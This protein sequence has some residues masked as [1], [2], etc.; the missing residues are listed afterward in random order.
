MKHKPESR[1]GLLILT[2]A[3]ALAG[4]F[5]PWVPH[6]AAGLTVLGLDLAEYVKF[7]SPVASGQIALQRELFYLPLVTGSIAASLLASRRSLPA[8]GRIALWLIAIPLALA[9]LPPAWNLET[10]RSAEFRL[11]IIAIA[12]CLIP[13]LG[14]PL[15]RYL[16]GRLVLAFIALL[17]IAAALLPAWG[18]LRVQ[19][20]IAELYRYPLLPGWGFW[21]C[22]AGNFLLALCAVA[23]MLPRPRSSRV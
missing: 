20:V 21:T 6:R 19:P 11:Q 15:T 13:V 9:M 14:V 3:I 8:L 5:G 16:P 22:L 7:L 18:F 10:F 1:W 17:A 2:G 4:Y 23:E 12:A